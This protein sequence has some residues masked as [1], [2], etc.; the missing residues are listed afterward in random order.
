MEVLYRLSYVG[1]YVDDDDGGKRIDPL[2]SPWPWHAAWH[3]R[4]RWASPRPAREEEDAGS[5]AT[6]W[7]VPEKLDALGYVLVPV[8]RAVD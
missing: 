3:T 7:V 8:T 6:N 2:Q 1:V 5:Q 4:R